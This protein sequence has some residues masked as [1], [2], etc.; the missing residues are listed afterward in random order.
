MSM[1]FS[2]RTT[3]AR[4]GPLPP[5]AKAVNHK[6]LKANREGITAA[7]NQFGQLIHSPGKPKPTQSGEG[8]KSTRKTTT[9]LRVDRKYIGWKGKIICLPFCFACTMHRWIKGS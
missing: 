4:T 7:F 1:K 2:D 6:P 8:T 9:G 5:L 3:S